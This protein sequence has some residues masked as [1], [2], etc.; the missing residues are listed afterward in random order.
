MP[1][2][3]LALGAVAVDGKLY[4]MGGTYSPGFQD[5]DVVEV[6][7][8][9]SEQWSTVAPMPLART[10]MVAVAV[11]HLIY[12]IGGGRLSQALTSVHIYD[13]S[14]DSWS[15]GPSLL[16]GRVRFAAAKVAGTMFAIGGT[17]SVRPPHPG[18]SSVETLEIGSEGTPFQINAG[19][20][21]AWFNPDTPGQGFFIT[22][23]PDI[24]AIFLAWFTY[25]TERPPVNATAILGEPGHRWLTAYGNYADNL[26]VL[27][28]EVTSGGIFD[29]A[30]P[31]TVQE[32]DGDI[33]L[34][35]SD[36]EN[37]TVSYDI[38]SLDLQG[39]IPIKR[40][41]LDNVPGCEEYSGSE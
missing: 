10:G 23:F 26:A 1:T 35:F 9:T 27:D 11:D 3:R 31:M 37:G 30:E 18:I 25:D 2:P 29:S 19:L 39:E 40:I 22:V 16:E 34:E 20:N 5:Y 41:A 13:T 8:P 7:N 6:Y 17:R 21:D 36:C 12:V 32:S 28:I 14:N 4:A 24:G 38:A 15:E 33:L